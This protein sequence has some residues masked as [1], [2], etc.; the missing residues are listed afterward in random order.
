MFVLFEFVVVFYPFGGGGATPLDVPED[1]EFWGGEGGRFWV[2]VDIPLVVDPL[3]VGGGVWVVELEPTVV[4]RL[5]GG[6]VVVP[7]VVVPLVV[8][9]GGRGTLFVFPV[10]EVEFLVG[11]GGGIFFPPGGP[12]CNSLFSPLF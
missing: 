11:G 3:G 2:V 1:V 4:E 10:V 12:F 6:G 7:E 9:W 8:P 5:G